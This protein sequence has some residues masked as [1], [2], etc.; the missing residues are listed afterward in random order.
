MITKR[1]ENDS[2]ARLRRRRASFLKDRL[3]P[4]SRDLF[5]DLMARAGPGPHGAVVEASAL[6][7]AELMIACEDLRGDLE[8]GLKDGD[9]KAKAALVNAVT[10][11]QSTT[12]R[13]RRAFKGVPGKKIP[14]L[15][16]N[17]QG[18]K[19]PNA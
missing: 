19:P 14:T 18:R 15:M 1:T 11:L 17:L 16:L 12:A 6:E 5:L 8:A 3:T 10:R 4:R 13:A 7:C 2:H 9:L